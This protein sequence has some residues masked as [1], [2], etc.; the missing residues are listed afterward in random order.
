ML[1]EIHADYDLG[2]I[3]DCHRAHIA[4]TDAAND[5]VMLPAAPTRR[6]RRAGRAR[7]A[8]SVRPNGWVARLW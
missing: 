4:N 8:T 1:T 2:R 6:S 3:S 7:R 5:S